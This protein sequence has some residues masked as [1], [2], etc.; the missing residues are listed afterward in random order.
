MELLQEENK[1]MK[2]KLASMSDDNEKL[3]GLKVR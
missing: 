1:E 2:S 3:A